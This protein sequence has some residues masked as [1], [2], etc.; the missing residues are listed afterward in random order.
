M[1]QYIDFHQW[2]LHELLQCLP[3][4]VVFVQ[5][6]HCSC[7]GHLHWLQ[8]ELGQLCR[9]THSALLQWCSVL[10]ACEASRCQ[11]SFWAKPHYNTIVFQRPQSH[12]EEC[13]NRSLIWRLSW[14][15]WWLVLHVAMLGIQESIMSRVSQ[16]SPHTTSDINTFLNMGLFVKEKWH[17]TT[18]ISWCFFPW[19]NLHWLF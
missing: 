13:E 12:C 3:S 18:F 19:W 11:F 7:L 4:P 10:L 6:S 16:L 17:L 1:R 2:R 8:G 9:S 5:E 15:F 14:H